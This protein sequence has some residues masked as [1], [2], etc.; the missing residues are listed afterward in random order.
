MLN[1]YYDD[2]D[3][4]LIRVKKCEHTYY[5]E[6]PPFPH[7]REFVGNTGFNIFLV[8]QFDISSYYASL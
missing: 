1:F 5:S 7:P 3:S 4:G 6:P 2:D 8:V